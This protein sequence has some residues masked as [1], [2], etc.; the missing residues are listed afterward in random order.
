MRNWA[1]SLITKVTCPEAHRF[2]WTLT[3]IY[4]F[5][6]T[7]LWDISMMLSLVIWNIWIKYT[8]FKQTCLV[9]YRY[10][11]FIYRK[12]EW[13]WNAGLNLTNLVKKKSFLKKRSIQ[14]LN[15]PRNIKKR[16]KKTLSRG[17][18]YCFILKYEKYFSQPKQ[19]HS[20]DLYYFKTLAKFWIEKLLQA[21]SFII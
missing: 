4:A 14:I 17:L 8:I 11:F 3:S 15:L 1:L 16:E 5:R 20:K 6:I 7:A 2:N 9:I 18:F 19:M 21:M 13:W 10:S 12:F